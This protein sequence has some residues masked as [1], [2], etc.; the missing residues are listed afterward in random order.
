M[1][2]ILKRKKK[3]KN[4]KTFLTSLLLI[5]S[6][7]AVSPQQW[8]V[9]RFELDGMSLLHY[10]GGNFYARGMT[11]VGFS[12]KVTFAS[13]TTLIIVWEIAQHNVLGR[14]E[15]IKTYGSYDRAVKN[16]LVDV[17]CGEIGLVTGLKWGKL[18]Y[19]PYIK[20]IQIEW[21]F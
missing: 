18:Y 20:Q 5:S 6:L 17:V 9:D 10:V 11:S 15:W 19:N 7:S 14:E 16:A 3:M 2:K 4:L 1:R 13:G 21:R 12:N 8:L